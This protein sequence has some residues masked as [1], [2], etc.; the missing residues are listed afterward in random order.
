LIMLVN[1]RSMAFI[2]N[3]SSYV[4]QLGSATVRK[5]R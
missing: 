2:G 3:A 5:R 1:G 4:A